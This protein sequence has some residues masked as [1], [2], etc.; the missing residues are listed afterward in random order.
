MKKIPTQEDVKKLFHYNDG[1]LYRVM[2]NNR[3]KLAGS[4]WHYK[5]EPYK[6]YRVNVFGIC[7]NVSHIVFL[8]HNGYLPK[9]IDHIDRNPLNNRIENLREVSRLENAKNRSKQKNSSCKYMGVTIKRKDNKKDIRNYQSAICSNNKKMYIGAFKTEEEAALAY[10]REAVRYHGE[11][12]N[13]NIIEP[14]KPSSQR[15][16]DIII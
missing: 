14:I 5:P 13:L 1:F 7:Y 16:M 11:F 15:G 3:L 8:F 9:I 12:A 2:A 6:K 4:I 10:N